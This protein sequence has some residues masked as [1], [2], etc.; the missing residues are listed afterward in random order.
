M[1]EPGCELLLGGLHER[2]IE[3]V[4]HEIDGAA[5]ETAAHHAGACHVHLAGQPVEEI[6]L[7]AAHLIETAEPEMGLVHHL[8]NGLVVSPLKGVADIE[9]PLHLAY[10]IFGAK[11][12]LLGNL[13]P[14]LLKPE[15]LRIAQELHLGM[16][17]ANRGSGVLAG[18][19]PVV[20]CRRGKLVLHA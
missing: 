19:A 14:D 15:S 7:L 1:A 5:S 17:L 4:L 20:I 11:E 3:L 10:D 2:L 12:V 9:N 6:K 16:S 18:P 8:S 13:R